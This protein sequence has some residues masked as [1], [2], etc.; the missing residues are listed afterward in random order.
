MSYVKLFQSILHS[1]IW[2]EPDSTRLVWITM[3]ALAD[4]DGIVEASVPGLADAARV[5]L[6]VCV[7]A[8]EKFHEPDKWSR[9]K[10]HGGRRIE[11]VDGGWR[12]LNYD[13]YRLKTDAEHKRAKDA[14]RSRRYRQRRKQQSVTDRHDGH[15]SSTESPH[16][17][18][19]IA[20]ERRAK[21]DLDPPQ[22]IVMHG[23]QTHHYAPE[24]FEPNAKC[25][26]L[27]A[28]F[29]IDLD[30]A[31]SK[32]RAHGFS[33]PKR[34]H[35]E[36]YAWLLKRKKWNETERARAGARSSPQD[37]LGTRGHERFEPDTDSRKMAESHEVDWQ[38][39]AAQCRRSS[40][41]M[42]LSTPEQQHAFRKRV[43]TLAEHRRV[44]S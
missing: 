9:T 4:R 7:K 35:D 2:R 31:L 6:D 34:W 21:E 13:A 15:D 30:E 36:F 18:E 28:E 22:T 17:S 29:K 20:T 8:L 10:E 16:R 23:S 38:A 40:K 12:I 42:R 14:E 11:T 37:D 33:G 3:L 32:F 44:G 24:D 1:T 39:L 25:K 41:F 26:T 5:E 27:A 43:E 19:K